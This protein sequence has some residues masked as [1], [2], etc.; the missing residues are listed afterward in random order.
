VPRGDQDIAHNAGG[1]P[2]DQPA[3]DTRRVFLERT[4]KGVGVGTLLLLTAPRFA[5]KLATGRPSGSVSVA[6][7]W[8]GGELRR[9]RDLMR[10]YERDEGVAVD[11]EP[12][13]D[14]IDAYLEAWS[15][16]G[17]LPDVAVLP[18]PG[19][20]P[21]Y[22]D[23]DDKDWIEPIHGE[24]ASRFPP[25]WRDL[26]T[27]S[28]QVYG[29]WIKAAHKSLLWY[30]RSHYESTLRSD[31]LEWRTWQDLVD[32]VREAADYGAQPPLAIGA[33]DGWVLTDWFENLLNIFGGLDLYQRLARGEACWSDEPVER[34]LRELARLWAIPNA[35]AGG[36]RA[37]LMEFDESV[38]L[39]AT[40]EAS[41]VLAP[42]FALNMHRE[43][44]WASRRGVRF[45][46]LRFPTVTEGQT[47]PLLVGGDFAVVR[48]ESTAGR[49]LVEWLTAREAVKEWIDE[50]GYL[51]PNTEVT[52]EDYGEEDDVARSLAREFYDV[53]PDQLRFDLSDQLPGGLNGADGRGSWLIL[54]DFFLDVTAPYPDVDRAVERA[55]ARFDR[56][57]PGRGC[58]S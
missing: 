9:F 32:A 36:R 18:R 40:G 53:G 28:G 45:H 49:R 3:D 15:G 54:T 19:L 42:D 47:H 44:D 33:G 8:S 5:W 39:V 41:M 29:A 48:R 13:G 34:S 26:V 46:R 55:V 14:E 17:R 30:D 20:I 4:A 35:I 31:P 2:R 10:K 50:P 11:V 7:G 37:V 6:V 22:V 12:V 43:I 52:V 57:A 16:T 1:A 24:V 56:A 38:A 58:A 23:D 27:F 51:V 25:A 21:G